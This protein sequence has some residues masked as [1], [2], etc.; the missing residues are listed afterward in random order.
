MSAIVATPVHGMGVVDT[1]TRWELLDNADA[2]AEMPAV[3]TFLRDS[4]GTKVEMKDE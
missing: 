4:M 3:R 1:A 2:H